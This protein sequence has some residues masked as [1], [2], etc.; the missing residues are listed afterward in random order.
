MKKGFKPGSLDP[1]LFTKTYDD[2]LFVCQIYVDDIIFGYTNQRYN[3]EFAYMMSEEYQMS[4]MGE[5]KFVNNAM[6]SSFL[7]R[8]T[9][10]T[11]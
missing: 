6:A 3:D 10:R 4:M 5:L 11:F 1:T 2:E 8:N 7:K 9:S